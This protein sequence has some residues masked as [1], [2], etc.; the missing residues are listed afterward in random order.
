MPRQGYPNERAQWQ[1]NAN[2]KQ[3]NLDRAAQRRLSR[4]RESCSL[5][6]LAPPGN[7]VTQEASVAT[8]HG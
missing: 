3:E 2:T 4:K 1:D 8:L 6:Q 7:V 5:C